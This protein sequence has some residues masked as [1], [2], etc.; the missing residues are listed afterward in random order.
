MLI[1]GL[2]SVSGGVWKGIVGEE[3]T[4]AVCVE[5]TETPWGWGSSQ[6][7]YEL[8]INFSPAPVPL[9][10]LGSPRKAKAKI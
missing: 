2:G 6:Y 4:T 9:P 8:G 10:T 3:E 5:N 7:R 1:G